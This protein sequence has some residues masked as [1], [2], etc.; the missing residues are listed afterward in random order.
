MATEGFF[1]LFSGIY[2]HRGLARGAWKT[3][4]LYVYVQHVEL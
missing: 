4:Y 3:G 2:L 1:F